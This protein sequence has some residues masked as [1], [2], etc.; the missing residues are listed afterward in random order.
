[1]VEANDPASV[2]ELLGTLA[3]DTGALMRQE[4]K[5]A[6]AEMTVKGKR[7][8]RSLGV[9]AAGG[10]LSLAGFL[11]LLAA[12]IA[13][14]HAVLPLWLS[15]L[16]VGLSVLGVGY[17]LISKGLRAIADI[18]PLPE[19]TLNTLSADVAWAKEEIR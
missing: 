2:G 6:S 8:A 7:L 15:A 11:A 3:R 4:L 5:L 1:M 12:G 17:A 18:E 14:L 19:Q 9:V 16:L 13:G 10:A